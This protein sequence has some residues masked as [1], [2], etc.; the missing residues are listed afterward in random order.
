M[1]NDSTGGIKGIRGIR[2][3]VYNHRAMD[4]AFVREAS[5]F[6]SRPEPRTRIFSPLSVINSL[7]F[8][9]DHLIRECN[10]LY[11]RVTFRRRN[12]IGVHNSCPLARLH[13][14]RIPSFVIPPSSFHSKFHYTLW[15]AGF[16][17]LYWLLV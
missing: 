5:S 9:R 15:D 2:D 7:A 17:M 4:P 6:S 10:L 8:A 16:I 14:G 13:S 1:C 11:G 12:R 3:H